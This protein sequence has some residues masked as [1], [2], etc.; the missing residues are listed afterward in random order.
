MSRRLL[1]AVSQFINALCGGNPGETISA[2][3]GRNAMRGKRWA[4]ALEWLIDGVFELLTGERGHCRNSGEQY[5]LRGRL[6]AQ[7]IAPE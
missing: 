6:E 7:G 1:I 3:V 2:R 5:E 4:L